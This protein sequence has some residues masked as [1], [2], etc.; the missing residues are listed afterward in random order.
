MKRIL[1]VDDAAT[2]RMFHRQILEA[3]GFA[4]EEAVNGVEALEKAM[5]S[6]FDLYLVDI[7]MPKMN[8]YTFVSQLRANRELQQA[9][10]VMISTE[11]ERADATRA[12]QAG[13]NFY[14]VKPC[15]PKRLAACARLMLGVEAR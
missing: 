5:S 10:V 11:S 3:A 9:P 12:Y 14:I 7:N 15:S 4:V 1:V 2:V 8:G 6:A 13:A